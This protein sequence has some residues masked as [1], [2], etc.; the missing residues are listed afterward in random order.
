VED[1]LT[2]TL[3]VALQVGT[4]A[5]LGVISLAATAE[6]DPTAR[7][8]S[9]VTPTIQAEDRVCGRLPSAD[10][11]PAHWAQCRRQVQLKHIAEDAT[12]EETRTVPQNELGILPWG[13]FPGVHG[14][15]SAWA[16]YLDGSL[17]RVGTG[18]VVDTPDR[19]TPSSPSTGLIVVET[20]SGLVMSYYV[21]RSGR[22]EIAAE[23]DGI[24]EIRGETGK[25][26]S[27]N[28]RT[29]KLTKH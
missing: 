3:R 16:G 20:G 14:E 12:S 13:E 6:G 23:H 19:G 21:R 17:Y 7:M 10:E 27:F 2:F 18:D 5:I 15:L 28:I 9:Y 4:S 29:R 26:Y 1:K 8:A 25:S 22:L 24:L 11:T